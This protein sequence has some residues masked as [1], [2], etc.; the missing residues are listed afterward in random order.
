GATRTE[1]P[2][3]TR[4]RSTSAALY[5]AIPPV[6]PSRTRM[7]V[8]LL[9]GRAGVAELKQAAGVDLAQRHGE[10][11]VGRIGLDQRANILEVTL[12]QRVVVGVDLAG[13]IGAVDHEGVLGVHLLEQLVDRGV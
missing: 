11:L 10:R 9:G 8:P 3:S 13:A 12:T 4:R 7:V 2:S 1:W 5:A 6:T